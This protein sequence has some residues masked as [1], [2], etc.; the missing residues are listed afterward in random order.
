MSIIHDALKKV[1]TNLDKKKSSARHNN[2]TPPFA[3][4]AR[5]LSSDSQNT[6]KEYAPDS[7]LNGVVFL[8][9][10]CLIVLLLYILNRPS[11]LR[12]T[13]QQYT[14]TPASS[15]KFPSRAIHPTNISPPQKNMPQKNNETVLQGTMLMGNRQVAL[16]NSEIYELGE[17]VNGLTITNITL[18]KVDLI[19]QNGNITILTVN[20]SD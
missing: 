3:Q 15:I 11:H 12:Q 18:K 16:I 5:S 6:V 17:S 13:P 2:N 20:K 4:R 14:A 19:D 9:I 1:Q 10:T 7:I 8:L